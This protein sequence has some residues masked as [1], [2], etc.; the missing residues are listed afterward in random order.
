[1]ILSHNK[2][3]PPRASLQENNHLED[4]RYKFFWYN[5]IP[6]K[7]SSNHPRNVNAVRRGRIRYED[8]YEEQETQH[9]HDSFFPSYSSGLDTV[10][11]S[12]TDPLGETIVIERSRPIIEQFGYGRDSPLGL[13]INGGPQPPGSR[14]RHRPRRSEDRRR[15]NE[16]EMRVSKNRGTIQGRSQSSGRQERPNRRIDDENRM[17]YENTMYYPEQ[18]DDIK[19]SSHEQISEGV[20]YW[21]K[22]V[23]SFFNFIRDML[24]F[25]LGIFISKRYNHDRPRDH[26]QPPINIY[27]NTDKLVD[28]M[29]TAKTKLQKPQYYPNDLPRKCLPKPQYY[30]PEGIPCEIIANPNLMTKRDMLAKL[31]NYKRPM[32]VRPPLGRILL[33]S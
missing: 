1:M 27:I 2:D 12:S 23:D 3:P 15:Y 30:Y 13:E 31:T 25:F 10:S 14:D 19:T 6:R 21:A 4:F 9:S 16:S 26:S 32:N 11:L 24:S 33:D 18:E 7:P 5:M 20:L 29:E 22:K 28:N 17:H 8:E